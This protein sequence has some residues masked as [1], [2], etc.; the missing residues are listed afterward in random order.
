[1]PINGTYYSWED[2]TALLPNGPQIDIE[3]IEYSDERDIEHVYGQGAAPRGVGRG[4]YK[5]EGKVTLRKEGYDFLLVWVATTG[6]SIYSIAPFTITVAYMNTD[7]GLR[8]D[9][10]L[11]VRFKKKG[12]KAAQG[13]KSFSVDLEFIAEDIEEN[14]VSSSQGL[15]LL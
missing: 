8:S 15:N 2:I 4:N 10:I 6:K 14:G 5:A 1:M 7:N 12:K 11:G 13:D 3:S 9:Q